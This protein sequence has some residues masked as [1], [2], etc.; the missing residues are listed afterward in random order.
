[1]ALDCIALLWSTDFFTLK[2]YP[3]AAIGVHVHKLSICTAQ[4]DESLS[5]NEDEA[6]ALRCDIHY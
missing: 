3:Q 4:E 2:E 1:M 5:S 6:L